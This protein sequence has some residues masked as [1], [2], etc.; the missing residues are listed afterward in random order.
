MTIDIF[1]MVFISIITLVVGFIAGRVTSGRVA[2]SMDIKELEKKNVKL[3]IINKVLDR[4][5][6]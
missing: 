2:M 5:R 3:R 6:C 4:D 1:T